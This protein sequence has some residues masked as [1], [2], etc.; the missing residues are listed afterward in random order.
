MEEGMPF[1]TGNACFGTGGLFDWRDSAATTGLPELFQIESWDQCKEA[2][3]AT[4]ERALTTVEPL[5]HEVH[6]KY[7]YNRR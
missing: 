6:C 3:F 5:E 4:T 1:T 2:C 7:Y